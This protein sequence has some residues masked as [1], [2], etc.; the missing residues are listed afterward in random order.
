MRCVRYVV[1]SAVVGCAAC[2]CAFAGQAQARTAARAASRDEAVLPWKGV[3]FG[4]DRREEGPVQLFWVEVDV[5]GGANR[6]D[7]AR[8]GDDPDGDGPY[9]T[10]LMRPSAIAE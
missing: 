1:V 4:Q 6:V 2:A 7:V 3:R 9:Q 8:G 5:T 10:K